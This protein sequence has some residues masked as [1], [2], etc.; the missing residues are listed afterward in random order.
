MPD[1]D[2]GSGRSAKR[3]RVTMP[4]PSPKTRTIVSAQSG[5]ECAFPDCHEKVVKRKKNGEKYLAG[6]LCHIY[7]KNEGSARYDPTRT[8]EEVN[9]DEN[10]LHLCRNHHRVV[11]ADPEG[12]P[13]PLLQRMKEEHERQGGSVSR[14]RPTDRLTRAVRKSLRALRRARFFQGFDSTNYALVLKARVREEYAVAKAV[15]RARALSVVRASAG[16]RPS[17]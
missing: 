7:G 10:L 3:K 13:A 11:D 4:S 6:D 17:W 15:A 5:D 1:R 9:A 12:Y 16:R 8:V 14:E 2:P